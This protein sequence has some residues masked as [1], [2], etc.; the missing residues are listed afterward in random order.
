MILRVGME[1]RGR[2]LAWIVADQVLSP[3]SKEK[4]LL[5]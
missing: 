1:L 3:Q 5:L 2:A 4:V